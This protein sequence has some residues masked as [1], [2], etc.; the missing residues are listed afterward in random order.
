MRP[1]AAIA[2]AALLTVVLALG[3]AVAGAS[4]AH[5]QI[6]LGETVDVSVN[7]VDG[8]DGG[9]GRAERLTIEYMTARPNLVLDVEPT[10]SS[11]VLRQVPLKDIG[12]YVVTVWSEGVPYY[13]R[14][15]GR[16][17]AGEEQT[18][19]VFPVTTDRS[20]VAI[21]GLNV[22]ARREQSL[23]QVEIMLQVR[24]DASPQAAVGSAGGSFGLALP[25]ELTNIAAEVHRGID[26]APVPTAREG[27]LLRLEVPL[28]PGGNRIRLTGA[29]PWSEG[30]ELTM[31]ADVPVEAWSML[32]APDWME[33]RSLELEPD[34]DAP[35]PG[36]K[37]FVG[38]RL[39]AGRTLAMRLGSGEGQAGEEKPL[40][41]APQPQPQPEPQP[42]KGG[43]LPLPI[44][45]AVG[46]VLLLLVIRRR[47]G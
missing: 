1:A 34:P 28:V 30:L 5:A 6:N 23:L 15:K 12:N 10:G 16:D 47:R 25:A 7:L 33:V 22:M 27:G 45:V 2:A 44:L 32:V 42:E 8:A 13:F 19:H 41:A 36:Y 38:P 9:P 14:R 37:R 46:V 11:F 18:F 39:E 40:F 43:G 35:V 31:G 20:A 17:L 29:V 24:N 21:S 3:G 26:P 4:K